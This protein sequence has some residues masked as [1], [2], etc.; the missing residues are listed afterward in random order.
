MSPADVRLV[1]FSLILI[2]LF[3]SLSLLS[4]LALILSSKPSDSLLLSLGTVGSL[5]GK[6]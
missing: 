5:G 2:Y 1:N 4:H 6:G 3:I